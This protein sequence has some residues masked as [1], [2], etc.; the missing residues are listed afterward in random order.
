LADII[1]RV[2]QNYNYHDNH[3][4]SETNTEIIKLIELEKS[5]VE[6]SEVVVKILDLYNDNDKNSDKN[7]D[8]NNNC[9]YD[10]QTLIEKKIE[11]VVII[12]NDTQVREL[13]KPGYVSKSKS[14]NINSVNDAALIPLSQD[15]VIKKY[16]W[17]SP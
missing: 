5:D 3:N 17:D 1:K 13:K 14:I 9:T 2:K 6:R 16:W 7:S 4:Q 10:N 15:I 8:K 12:K 11:K